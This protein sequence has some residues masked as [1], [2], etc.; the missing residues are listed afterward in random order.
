MNDLSTG[1]YSVDKNIKFETPMVKSDLC[2]YSDLHI[3][4]KETIDLLAAATNEND[5]AQKDAGFKYNAPFRPCISK[6]SSTLIDNTE[7]LDIVM[8]MYNILEYSDNYSVTSESLW[9]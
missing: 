4:L 6:M 3:V 7:D 5:K 1:Q 8:S 2:N 9:N